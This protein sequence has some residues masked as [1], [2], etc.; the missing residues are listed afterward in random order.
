MLWRM[1]NTGMH[2]AEDRPWRDAQRDWLMEMA[3]T[4]KRGVEVLVSDRDGEGGE[5]GERVRVEKV[6][7]TKLNYAMLDMAFAGSP[8]QSEHETCK[9]LQELFD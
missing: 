2:H 9:E 3:Q 8:N 4:P 5:D 1:T 6:K 7:K